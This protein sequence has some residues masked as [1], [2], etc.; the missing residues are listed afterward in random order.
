MS[1]IYLKKIDAT[2]QNQ[3]LSNLAWNL[4]EQII[5]Q[6]YKLNIKDLKLSYNAYGKPYFLNVDFHFNI[7]HSKCLIA[8]ALSKQKIGID[9][10]RIRN[11]KYP[12][13]FAK[14][15]K[16][17]S[18]D[19]TTIIKRFSAL[20]AYFKKIGTGL[21]YSQLQKDI[22]ISYQTLLTVEKDQYVLSIDMEDE[23]EK[24]YWV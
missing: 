20:E 24:I 5:Y 19:S 13:S 18:T 2:I 12:L 11:L 23:I 10:E 16:V 15:L 4:L 6:E 9:V 14:K 22:Q 8:I 17:M 7:S 21:I 3:N 1:K